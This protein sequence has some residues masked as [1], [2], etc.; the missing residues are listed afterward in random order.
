MPESV[1]FLPWYYAFLNLAKVYVILGPLYGKLSAQRR[2][3]F[4]YN[5]NREVGDM[6]LMEDP[7]YLQ[8]RNGDPIGAIPL[9]YQTIIGAEF[10]A[11]LCT[12][13]MKDLFLYTPACRPNGDW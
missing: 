8:R 11:D 10:P 1:S 2:P 6:S 4:G 9:F 13:K 12:L 3:G 5:P 7:K